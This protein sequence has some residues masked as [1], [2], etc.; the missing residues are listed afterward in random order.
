M[1][2]VHGFLCIKMEY[3]MPEWRLLYEG[4]VAAT[5]GQGMGMELLLKWKCPMEY[6]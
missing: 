1:N 3:G 5:G 4:F 6:L 2:G